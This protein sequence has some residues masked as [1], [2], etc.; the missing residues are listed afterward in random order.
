MEAEEGRWGRRAG[1]GK[2]RSGRET[3]AKG[4]EM[5]PV[6]GGKKK[7]RW[8]RGGKGVTYKKTDILYTGR[9]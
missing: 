5:R 9:H 3:A 7:K 4:R 2:I 1:E 8:T 6:E